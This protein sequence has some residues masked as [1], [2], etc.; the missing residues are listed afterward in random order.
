VSYYRDYDDDRQPQRRVNS[1]MSAFKLRLLIAVAIAAFSLINYLASSSVNSITGE[2]QRV[3]G[4]TEEQ[5]IRLGLE[6]APEMANQMGGLSRDY[7]A[8]RQVQEMGARLVNSLYQKLQNEGKTIPYTFDFHLLADNQVVNAFALPGGQV[9]ITEALYRRF[10][11][12][13]QLAGVLGHEI[14]HVLERH[15]AERMAQGSL[16]NGIGSA[17][18]VAGGDMRSG[19][20]A[21]MV[22]NMVSMRYGRDAEL[23]S[24]K[25]GVELMVLTGY[26]PNHMLEVM[27]I[28]EESSGGGGTP[29]FLSTHP[30]PAHRREYINQ[31]IADRFPYGIPDGLK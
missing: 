31:V 27:D 11:H 18:G 16:I 28:L 2:K 20:M 29:E 15:G 5:E 24:D 22:G 23:E 6:A 26:H 17:A 10:T 4:I 8:A 21:Q 3:G 14:G 7:G 25:W 9:F 13:G 1:G 19:Q 30:R 12:T